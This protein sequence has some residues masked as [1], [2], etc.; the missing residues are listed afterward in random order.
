MDLVDGLPEK[1][2]TMLA[3]RWDRS[4]TPGGQT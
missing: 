3:A 1:S 4:G 2:E